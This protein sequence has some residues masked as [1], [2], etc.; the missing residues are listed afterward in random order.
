MSEPS[1]LGAAFST[2]QSFTAAAEDL[3]ETDINW[4]LDALRGINSGVILLN[5]TITNYTESLVAIGNTGTA[6][7]LSLTGGTVQ[8]ATLTGNC[9]FTMPAVVPGKSTSFVLLLNTGA[10]GFTATFTGVKWDSGGAPTITTA[11][12]KMDRLTFLSAGVEWFGSY[13]Q[14]YTP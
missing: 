5:P 8:T 9:V 10:G 12:S 3:D 11:A 6:Q 2:G 4:L 13:N 14:G 1:D 7:T